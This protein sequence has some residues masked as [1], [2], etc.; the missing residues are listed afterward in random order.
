MTVTIK[1]LAETQ[2][3]PAAATSLY[4]APA[5]T[6][7]IID[8]MTVANTTGGAINL[9]AYVV[10]SGGSVGTS[11]KLITARPLAAGASDL[12]PE[13]VG[14]ILQPGDAIYVEPS[15][16]GTTGRISGREVV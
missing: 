16:T 11:T 7:A 13:I 4:A 15:A 5:N 8:K 9:T 1:A 14:H 3:I 10:P 12:C 6:K 2:A